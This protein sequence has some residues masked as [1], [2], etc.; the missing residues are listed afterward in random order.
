M[1]HIF[2]RKM[3]THHLY[4]TVVWPYTHD[5]NVWNVNIV[6][7]NL[8]AKH[9]LINVYV[10]RA[11]NTLLHTYINTYTHIC[12]DS[13][14]YYWANDEHIRSTSDMFPEYYTLAILHV[15]TFKHTGYPP[16]TFQYYHSDSTDKIYEYYLQITL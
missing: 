4:Y 11:G 13:N 1:S 14:D 12:I 8:S 9:I 5:T 7:K 6:I 15:V 3:N 2:N 10:R 16:K